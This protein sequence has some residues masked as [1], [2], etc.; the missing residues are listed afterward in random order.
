MTRIRCVAVL[1]ALWLCMI[2]FV[3]PAFADGERCA[4]PRNLTVN[5]DMNTFS[6]YSSE[7]NQRVVADGWFFWVEEGNPAFIVGQDSPVPPSQ[8]IWSDGGN[9]RAGIY[10]QVNNLTP[11]ATY[12]AGAGW[13]PYTSPSGTIMRQIGIDPFGGTNP[14]AASV[15]WGPEDWIFS[16]F[17]NLEVRAVAQSSTITIFIRVYNPVSHGQDIIFIDGANL[18][19]DETVPVQG[20]STPTA[21]PVPATNT[22]E[23]PTPTNTPE[24]LPPTNTAEPATATPIL[25]TATVAPP[26]NTAEP[27]TATSEPA[28]ATVSPPTNTAVPASATTAPATATVAV[29]AASTNT[30]IPATKTSVPATK[31]ASPIPPTRTKVATRAP[32]PT[33]T[34]SLVS[35]AIDLT[36]ITP[37]AIAA[38]D[39]MP[40]RETTQ[41]DAS[42]PESS[43]LVA[44]QESAAPSVGVQWV[45]V[46]FIGL[47]TLLVAGVVA[48]LMQMRKRP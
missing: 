39:P 36:T 29:R 34:E 48:L 3:T 18:L 26:T 41:L 46:A 14:T 21:S 33:A 24:P 22:P 9:F 4:D 35:D 30:A 40:D 7:G 8:Q 27:A 17:T 6:D 15:I 13:V 20:A 31:T 2:A 5:C 28:T 1:G 44:A 47:G 16:R 19:L 11:G 23:P 10:Q 38:T 12:I 43:A 42:A 32:E 25:P 45:G 37:E